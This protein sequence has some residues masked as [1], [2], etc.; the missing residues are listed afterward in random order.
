MNDG[1]NIYYDPLDNAIARMLVQ[2]KRDPLVALRE[3]ARGT[4]KRVIE[5]TPPA[6]VSRIGTDRFRSTPDTEISSVV[7]GG[8]A[9]RHGEAKVESDIRKLYGTPSDAYAMIK[10]S[11]ANEGEAAGF[12]QHYKKGEIDH[13]ATLFRK[14]TGRGFGAFDDGKLHKSWRNKRG[15]VSAKGKANFF[16]SN[17]D[18]L[19]AYIR[20]IKSHVGWLAAGWNQ[21]CAMLGVQPPQWIWRHSSPG[22]GTVETTE[23]R[24]TI[25]MTNRVRYVD[26]INDW[27]RRIQ[28]AVNSQAAALNR[29]SEDYMK[30]LFQNQGFK[31]SGFKAAA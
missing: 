30:K 11:K 24:V 6:H 5:I 26:N 27:Q 4:L 14:A 15:N 7:L 19:K 13:A 31:L 23:S 21:A 25:T 12:W 18:A 22:A 3:V 8:A 29:R 20:L 16:V 10:A 9:K 28:Y 17:P 2:S 1:I